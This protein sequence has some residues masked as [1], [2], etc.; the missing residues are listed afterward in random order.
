MGQSLANKVNS[1]TA[2]PLGPIHLKNL[3][4]RDE[5]AR[6]DRER[7]PERTVHVKGA[8]NRMYALCQIIDIF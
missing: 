8:G 3:Q 7:I 5:M 2:S 4:L 6:I 1:L